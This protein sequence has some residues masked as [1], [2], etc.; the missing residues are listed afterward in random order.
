M[1]ILSFAEALIVGRAWRVT[2]IGTGF[3]TGVSSI[4]PPYI[5]WNIDKLL[6]INLLTEAE[7]LFL[8]LQDMTKIIFDEFIPPDFGQGALEWQKHQLVGEQLD[9]LVRYGS[10]WMFFSY[11]RV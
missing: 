2:N 3:I 7:E 6:C 5:V 1:L 9:A 11:L 8:G 4:S 10:I